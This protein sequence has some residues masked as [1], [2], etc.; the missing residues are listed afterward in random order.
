[1]PNGV[2]KDAISDQEEETFQ[3][4]EVERATAACHL[5]SNPINIQKLERT[6]LIL[7]KKHYVNL[8]LL[9]TVAGC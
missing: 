4:D 1:M 3:R 2:E 8:Y 5:I 7:P 6:G 9:G